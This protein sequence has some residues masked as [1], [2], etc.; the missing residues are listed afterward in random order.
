MIGPVTLKVL[1]L[2]VDGGG[3]EVV[4]VVPPP[5]ESPLLQEER[6]NADTVANSIRFIIGFLRYSNNLSFG[7]AQNAAK[8]ACKA[9]AALK[10]GRAF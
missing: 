1:P 7:I 4:G 9:N 5:E 8:L 10:R 6:A 3:V 2:V